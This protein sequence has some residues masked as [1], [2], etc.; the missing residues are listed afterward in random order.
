MLNNWKMQYTKRKKIFKCFNI[1]ILCKA[2]TQIRKFKIQVA[3]NIYNK[4]KR[5]SLIINKKY[6][7]F[8]V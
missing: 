7:L 2:G 5:C 1:Y 4:E 6:Q 8:F 3:M